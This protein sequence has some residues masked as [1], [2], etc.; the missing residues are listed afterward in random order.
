[1][2][3]VWWAF[4]NVR[5][6]A[7]EDPYGETAARNQQERMLTWNARV[8]GEGATDAGLYVQVRLTH[9]THGRATRC[10]QAGPSTG[11]CQDMYEGIYRMLHLGSKTHEGMG[12]QKPP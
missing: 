3:R 12:T 8:R 9:D 6:G 10:G 2:Q 4:N 5:G 7:N 1:M 11:V